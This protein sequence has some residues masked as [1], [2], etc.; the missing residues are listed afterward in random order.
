RSRG[1]SGVARPAGLAYPGW[2]S[3]AGEHRLAAAGWGHGRLASGGARSAGFARS[4]GLPHPGRAVGRAGK[5][6]PRLKEAGGFAEE[7]TGGAAGFVGAQV[8]FVEGGGEAG[9]GR[10]AVE[11]GES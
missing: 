2:A 11:D 7:G 8:V 5:P 10:G 6:T 1:S 9:D 3:G 4:P